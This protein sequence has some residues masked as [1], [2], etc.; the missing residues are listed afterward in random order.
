MMQAQNTAAEVTDELVQDLDIT[1]CKFK[2]QLA[3]VE[4]QAE[5]GSCRTGICAGT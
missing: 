2:M 1:W 3:K 5:I 4:A